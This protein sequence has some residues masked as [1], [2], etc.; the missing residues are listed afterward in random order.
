MAG[1]RAAAAPPTGRGRRAGARALPS[2]RLARARALVLAAGLG[3]GAPA[4][5]WGHAV[6]LEAEP[7][8]DAVLARA[9]ARIVLRFN[10][11]IEAGLTRVAL[12]TGDG[13]AVA[14]PAGPAG[15]V[16]VEG[17]D[18]LAVPLAPLPPGTYVLR[19]RVLAADGHVT[20]GALRFT[21][22][23]AR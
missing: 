21:V 7:A 9:P 11:R 14:Q 16:V 4:A 22:A 10:S 12:T 3:L 15:P 19:Y 20:E 23:G 6:V 13:R 5:G 17:P 2:L 8:H 1:R 18:R